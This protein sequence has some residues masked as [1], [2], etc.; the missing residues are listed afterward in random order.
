MRDGWTEVA[1]GDVAQI[2]GGGTPKSSVPAYWGGDVQWL[3]PKDLSDRPARYTS[4]GA[5][6]ITEAGL[7]SSGARI[8]PAGAVLLTS[9]APVGYVSIAASPIATNQGFK[10]LVLKDDQIP[11]FWY[12]LLGHSTDYLRANSGGSTFQEI[13]GGALKKL[14]FL[15]PPL[16]EQRRIVDLMAAV[17]SVVQASEKSLLRAES[18]IVAR[19][20]EIV[21]SAERGMPFEEAAFFASGAAFPIHA[22]GDSEGTIPFIKVSDMNLPGNELRIVTANHHVTEEGLRKL[23]ARAWPAGTVVFPKVGAALLTEKRRVLTKPTAFD[24][25]VMGVIAREGVVTPEFLF[26]FMRTVKLGD[27]AQIGALPSVNQGHLRSLIVPSYSLERQRQL[28]EE[29]AALDST[30]AASRSYVER[31][32]TLR[33]GIVKTCGSACHAA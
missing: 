13:S 19:V 28:D 26:T 12:L 21:A 24:N 29:V 22:Q 33:G 9:R 1:V 11:E 31:L 6:T 15:L 14:R 25:N 3:T 5:R 27:Y 32:R 4:A 8:L 17:D 10:S 18:L 30:V 2:V 20:Q 16:T 23:R 7:K